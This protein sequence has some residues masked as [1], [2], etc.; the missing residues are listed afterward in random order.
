MR[1]PDA[2]AGDPTLTKPQ[3]VHMT[4]DQL[5]DSLASLHWNPTS[6]ASILGRHTTTTRRWST[7]HG[8]IPENVAQWLRRMVEIHDANPPPAPPVPGSRNIAPG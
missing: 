1:H 7:G 2:A 8:R 3:P 4:A 6:L 5:A